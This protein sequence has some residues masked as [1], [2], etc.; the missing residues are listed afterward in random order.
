MEWILIIAVGLNA[1]SSVLA[2]AAKLWWSK[3]YAESKNQTIAAK[4]AQIE[5]LNAQI[6]SLREL[7]PM[8]IR[9]YFLSIKEQL[10]EYIAHLQGQ[11]EEL[12]RQL[13]VAK[14]EAEKSPDDALHKAIRVMETELQKVDAQATTFY[15]D[16]VLSASDGSILS[17]A[18]VGSSENSRKWLE[19]FWLKQR[20]N[21]ENEEKE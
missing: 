8:K 12:R 20:R 17:L 2:W 10:E 5:V 4:E 16:V 9:E 11:L 21:Q 15:S 6:A 7:N 13:D 3:E 14:R 18:N 1:A 19:S